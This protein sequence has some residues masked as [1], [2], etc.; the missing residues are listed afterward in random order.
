[1]NSLGV[2]VPTNPVKYGVRNAIGGLRV[3]WLVVVSALALAGCVSTLENPT[4]QGAATAPVER[5]LRPSRADLQQFAAVVARIEPVA[6]S[7]CRRLT[8]NLNC[9]FMIVVDAQ[10]GE[11]PNAYQSLDDSGRPVLTFNHAMIASVR[12]TYELAFVVGHE[13]AHHISG[14]VPR[15]Q[16]DALAGAILLGGTAWVTGASDERISQALAIGGTLGALYYS[17]DYEL[18]ADALGTVIT[19]RAGYNP[20]RGAEFFTQLPDPGNEFLGTHPP[21]ADRIETVRRVN[22]GL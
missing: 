15:T 13:A 14:H 1:M 7:E 6:E 21:H 3:R 4:S 20:V 18:E 16:D 10:R 22:A 12:N 11:P 2:E 17:K 8:S 19:K 5:K 9:D